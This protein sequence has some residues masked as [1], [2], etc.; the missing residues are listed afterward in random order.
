MVNNISTSSS[1]SKNETVEYK[2]QKLFL[3]WVGG[4]TQIIKYFFC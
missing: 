3:K 1:N 4:K 2:L